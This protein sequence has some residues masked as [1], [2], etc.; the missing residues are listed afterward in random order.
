MWSGAAVAYTDGSGAEPQSKVRG[1][2]RPDVLYKCVTAHTSQEG[3]EPS[4]TPALWAAVN[5]EQAGTLDDPIPA[6]RGMEY[7][8]GRYYRDPEDGKTY[9]CTRDDDARPGSGIVL[10]Y[11]PHELAGQYFEEVAP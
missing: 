10:Q 2:A 9:L 5:E 1:Q 11:L 6:V 8:Q 7:F 4:Q 3:W